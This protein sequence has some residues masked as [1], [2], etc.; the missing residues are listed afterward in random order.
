MRISRIAAATG[1]VFALLLAQA[2]AA[3]ISSTFDTGVEGW[4]AVDTTGHDYFST[5][6]STGG[7]PGG[8]LF[9]YEDYSITG[10]GFFIAPSKFLGDLSAYA[11]GV[12]SFDIKIIT[13]ASRYYYSDAD[14]IISN[15][16]NSVSW[17]PDINPAEQGWFTFSVQLNDANFGSGLASILSNVTE[18]QIR[19]EYIGGE[20][21][22]GLDNVFLS[23]AATAVPLPAVGAGLP[24][25]AGFGAMRAWYRRRRAIT[26]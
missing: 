2:S 19:G 23:T 14:V 20:E 9:G 8:F 21:E 7:N 4:T 18:L 13:G 11:G 3:T 17:T 26:V 6:K 15:G 10:T 22:E 25:V 1:V 12:L 5:W 24:L 16:A